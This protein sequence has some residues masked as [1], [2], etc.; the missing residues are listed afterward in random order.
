MAPDVH[1]DS[2]AKQEHMHGGS[3]ETH[4]KYTNDLIRRAVTEGINAAGEPLDSVM[5]RWRLSDKD[6]D[7][8]VDYLKQL[9]AG[10]EPPPE[11]IPREE[12][13]PR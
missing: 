5:P 3:T 10:I 13:G 11:L 2:L 4:P 1:Y 6:F 9:S 8:L 12:E 7:D